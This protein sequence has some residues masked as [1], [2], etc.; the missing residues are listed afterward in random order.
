MTPAARVSAAIGLLDEILTFKRPLASILKDWGNANR[1]AGS[2]DRNA[3]GNLVHDALRVKASSAWMMGQ[4]EAGSETGR[5]V[6][7]GMMRRLRGMDPAAITALCTGE[8]FAPAP[9]SGAEL[10]ALEAASLEGAPPP[11]L[12]DYPD[13]LEPNLMAAFGEARVAEAAAMAA[14][15]PVDLRVNAL[16]IIRMK[17]L[18]ALGHLAPE[19]TPLSPLGLRLL[20]NA[21]GRVPHV[22]SEP[23]F[24][25]G[26]VEIQDEGS[27][28]VSLLAGAEPGQQVLDLCAGGG[29][30]TL[31]L[32]AEMNNKGQIFAT[33]SDQRRLAPIHDRLTRAGVR[34]VQ[35]R[36]PRNGV[37][38]LDDL[39]G[40][41]DLVLVDAPCTGA[42]TWRRHPD[43]KWRMRPNSLALRVGEQ[44]AVLDHAAGFVRPGGRLVYI[45]CSLL[46]D[47]NGQQVRAFLA[48]HPGFAVED[49]P[50]E[51]QRRGLGALAG[52]RDASGLGLLLTPHRT[53]TDGFFIAALSRTA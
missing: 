53:N 21:E 36:T 43:A 50:A 17:A 51:A 44:Q 30:K 11:V 19:P 12:G 31:A 6:V 25:K 4:R 41:M 13:W 22:Q 40:K 32:A 9:L 46:D 3:V 38:P 10:A 23:A 27:Q 42:G 48:R 52:H 34:N 14:R 49:L 39:A 15:A 18:E 1:Y 29:G 35:V 47:E 45:T 24:L 7:L 28:L 26:A 2:G 5:G 20:P 16:K 8:R 33:D 37:M